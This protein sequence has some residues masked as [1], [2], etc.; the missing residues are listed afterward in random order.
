MELRRSLLATILRDEQHLLIISPGGKPKVRTYN[1]CGYK[2]S[3][4]FLYDSNSKH[5]CHT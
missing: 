3:L 1:I 5:L 4:E 2:F